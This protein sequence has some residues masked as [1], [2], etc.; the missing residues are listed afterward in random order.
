MTRAL[1]QE[2]G[3]SPLRRSTSPAAFTTWIAADLPNQTERR[4]VPDT[5]RP[6]DRPQL[7]KI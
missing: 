4:N 5:G 7:V 1:K 2:R 3:P 6:N